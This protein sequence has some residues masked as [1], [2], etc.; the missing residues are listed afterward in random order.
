ML[1]L[2]LLH[3]WTTQSISS[4]VDF[5]SC[6]TLFQTTVVE[7]GLTYPFLMHEILSLAALHLS[8]VN[9]H[10]AALYRHA[11]D[12]HLATGLSLFQREIANIS[13]ENCHAC[14]AF[15]VMVFTHTWASQENDKPSTLFFAPS[16]LRQDLDVVPVQWVRLHRSSNEIMG[17]L[18]HLITE[19]P[20]EPLFSPWNGLD[21]DRP[22][23]LP[24]VEEEQLSELPNTWTSSSLSA[25]EKNTLNTILKSLRRVFNILA[26]N[27]NISKLSAVMSWFSMISDEYLKMLKEKIPEALLI[28]AFYCVALKRA[29]HMWWMRGKGENLLR[30]VMGE[31]G[32]EWEQWTR[33]PVEQ[34]LG[35]GGEMTFFGKEVSAYK[36]VVYKRVKS[37][38]GGAN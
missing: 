23:P 19:G 5:P 30:T 27:P 34:V 32:Q 18:F 38:N 14:F 36:T 3:F 8:E 6:I 15:S 28:V 26:Y 25:E 29:E 21:P 22:D 12:T 11:S 24:P 4:F 9:A 35:A 10:R 13:Q 1:D 31:L 33:W 2:E 16:T 17:T 7:M 37:G 20:L